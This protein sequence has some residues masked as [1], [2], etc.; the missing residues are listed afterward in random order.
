MIIRYKFVLDDA[1]CLLMQYN[2]FTMLEQKNK[3]L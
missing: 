1:C 3:N 2:N